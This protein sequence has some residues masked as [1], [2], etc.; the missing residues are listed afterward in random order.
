MSIARRTAKRQQGAGTTVT[1]VTLIVQNTRAVTRHCAPHR[2]VFTSRRRPTITQSNADTRNRGR[3]RPRTAYGPRR[4]AIHGVV[5]VL[6]SISALI[7]TPVRGGTE[8]R[9]ICRALGRRNSLQ[10]ERVVSDTSADDR[11][12]EAVVKDAR[13]S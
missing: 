6:G 12:N 9:P 3:E 11:R 4:G 10:A 13:P 5:H 8:R 2:I 1:R 7:G